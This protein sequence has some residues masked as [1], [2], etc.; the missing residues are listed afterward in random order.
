MRIILVQR[1]IVKNKRFGGLLWMPL[2]Y[3]QYIQE[4]KRIRRY[5]WEDLG[6]RQRI[7]S[8][9]CEGIAWVMFI[10]IDGNVPSIYS[11][12]LHQYV[13]YDHFHRYFFLLRSC[14]VDFSRF[15][16]AGGGIGEKI[17]KYKAASLFRFHQLQRLRVTLAV[18]Q[19]VEAHALFSPGINAWIA[20]AATLL[21]A[22]IT[23]FTIKR[24]CTNILISKHHIPL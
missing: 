9:L 11:H 5:R 7:F 23:Y 6:N 20:L 21:A 22:R 19:E 12:R 18:I 24:P 13:T 16:I 14:L 2:I 15:N 4:G 8:F 17:I 1:Y 3:P 10:I